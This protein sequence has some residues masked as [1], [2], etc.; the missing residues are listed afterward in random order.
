M[1]LRRLGLVLDVVVDDA[2]AASAR[3]ALA[4]AAW[5]RVDV[6]SEVPD[7][8]VLPP[9][10]T[11]VEVD[12]AVFR[13][14]SSPAWVGGALPLGDDEWVVLDTDPDASGLKLDQHNRNLVRQLAG[15]TNGD[16]ATSA[17]GTLRATGFA[18]AR[19]DRSKR[20]RENVKRAEG[21]AAADLAFPLLFDDVVR[22][23]RVEVWDDV[24]R[25]WHSLHRRLVTATAPDGEPL[26]QELPAAG[27]LQLSAL[28]TGPG[29]PAAGYYVNE[30]VAGWDGWSLSAPRPGLTIVHVSPPGPGGL[31]EEVVQTPPDEPIDGVQVTTTV[32]PGTLPRLRYGTSYS[33]RILA[34]DLAGNSVP[35]VAPRRR[36]L[37]PALPRRQLLAAA[38]RHLD[39]LQAAYRARD[40]RGLAARINETLASALEPEPETRVQLPADLIPDVPVVRQALQRLLDRAA[41]QGAEPAA[42][43][44]LE[45]VDRAATVL[46]RSRRA[47][48]VRPLGVDAAEF[49]ELASL[50][51]L[52]LPSDSRRLARPVVTAPR[53]YLR[54][55]PVPAPALVARRALGTGEQLANLVIRSGAPGGAEADSRA[56]SERHLVPPKASQLEAETAGLFD[57]A[58]G[59]GDAAEMRRLYAVALAERGTLLDERVSSLTDPAATEPQ[60][61]ISLAER[62]GADTDSAKRATLAQVTAE[63]G[64]AL[65]EGQYVVHDVDA[66][67]LPYLPDPFAKGVGLVFFEAGIPHTL[68]DARAL[69]AVSVPYA[70]GWPAPQPLRLVLESGPELD[71]RVEGHVVHVAVP[72]GEQVRLAL[73]ST[74]AAG[75]LGKFGLW[76][77]HV[78]SIADPGDGFTPDELVASAALE[79]AAASGWLWW[80]SPAAE[81]RLVNAVPVPVRAPALSGVEVFL[82]PPGK[83]LV[84]LTGTVDVHG[85]STAQLV[86]RADWS[87]PVDN[88]DDPEPI[89]LDK[90]DVV[91]RSEVGE[92]QRRGLLFLMDYQPS[93]ALAP[94]WGGLGFHKFMQSFPDTRHRRVTYTPAGTTRYAEYFPPSQ[95]PSE[96]AVGAPVVVD[97]PSSARPSAPKVLEAVPLLLWEEG[98][99]PQDAFAFRQV[100]R[101]GVRIWLER[102]WY[103]S[104]DGELLGVLVFDTHAWQE[105]P[106]SPGTWENNPKPVQAPDGATSMW[107]ADPIIVHGGPVSDATVPPLLT[108]EHLLL[109]TWEALVDQ[110]KNR[111]PPLQGKAPGGSA[112][113]WP[114]SPA[115]PVAAAD[116]VPLRDVRGRPRARVLAYA[117]EYHRESRRWFVDV[118]VNQT[119]ALWPFLRLA[120]ARY[121]PNSIEGCSLSPVAITGWVQPLPARTLTVSRPAADHVQVTLTGVVSWLR[122][123][124]SRTELPSELLSADAP[125]GDAAARAT[126]LLQSRTIR[127]TLQYLPDGAGDLE[128]ENLRSVG[129]AATSVD[130]TGTYTA[131]WS[132]TLDLPA[133]EEPRGRPEFR[134]PGAGPS[135]WRVLV[136]EHELLNAD[137]DPEP[138]TR[139]TPRLVY[140]GEIGL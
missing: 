80:L 99:E 32:A 14:K 71:A 91:V 127:A 47:G 57:A 109:D 64:R 9:R 58:I 81:L 124:D 24:T 125:T 137:P 84:T 55:E 39:R 42:R 18:I 41:E 105:D 77:S 59:T 92:R 106:E 114:S 88:P 74:L 13:A 35:Q 96:G 5:V 50:G 40:R 118:G 51:D 19:R 110:G 17:P 68:T 133:P 130:E 43:S 65:G 67:R 128:W 108:A 98:P 1:L 34:V 79:R 22:G 29:G 134:R 63:R 7:L 66:L 73:S 75:D 53:P 119:P 120:V 8:E 78:A 122:F 101:S 46:A 48:R 15:E 90:S 93:V 139:G 100:R 102:P 3:A 140:A 23:I 123:D 10:S 94:M 44:A 112:R 36:P 33:F 111:M 72:P 129:L 26:C 97:V 103:S 82:R 30:V 135:A 86:V 61:G 113:A 132:G 69:Q 116:S 11:A 2:D 27:F 16:P 38:S 21:I 136:E 138:G 83:G 60:S 117:P 76:R 85:P 49:V 121:Q 62:P 37:R 95:V 70:G 4:G 87:E 25:E 107:A 104:G 6:A 28:N 56:T 20:L 131:T 12:G 45:E 89:S 126:R 115:Q 52:Q 54:W 31:T